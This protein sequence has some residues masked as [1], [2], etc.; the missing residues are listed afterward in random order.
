MTALGLVAL[1]IGTLV[2]HTAA[3]ISIVL[4]LQFVLPGVLS[5]IPGSLGEHLS[6]ALPRRQRDRQHRAQRDQRVLAAAGG[7]ILL[8]WVAVLGSAALVSIKKR[9]V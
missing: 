9:D 6:N 7:L 3:G 2:R 8:G 4:A 1:S 5:L